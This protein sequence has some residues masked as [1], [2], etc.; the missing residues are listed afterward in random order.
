MQSLGH[1]ISIC[2]AAMTHVSTL[3]VILVAGVT[4]VVSLWCVVAALKMLL[5]PG[6]TEP[7]HPK[8][9]ILAPDR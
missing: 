8:R 6:E 2:G 1:A 9:R 4:G 3:S 7:D 5:R